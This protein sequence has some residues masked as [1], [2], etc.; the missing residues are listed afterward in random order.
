MLHTFSKVGKIFDLFSVSEPEWGVSEVAH[1]LA[2]PKS[3]VCEVMMSLAS[4]GLLFRTSAGR[5]RLGWRLIE[6]GNTLQA[7]TDF[8]AE[9]R[10]EMKELVDRWGE[11]VHLSVLEGQ[12]IVHVEKLHEVSYVQFL[13]SH[14]SMRLPAYCSSVGKVL[15]ASQKWDKV[16]ALFQDQQ[17]SAFTPKTI[18][19]MSDLAHELKRVRTQGYAYDD[20]EVLPGL[21]CISAPIYDSNGRVIAGLSFVVP[22]NRFHRQAENYTTAI[23]DAAQ[24]TSK[25]M[26]YQAKK[27]QVSRQH[28]PSLHS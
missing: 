25:K 7:T 1:A 16:A 13:L 24:R 14:M 4:Q 3:S 23:L 10:L 6:L 26:G 17:L 19:T 20:E 5:Y 22:A 8:Y 21:C 15:L 9:A 28:R 11:T 12:Q 18:T 27:Q 2:M